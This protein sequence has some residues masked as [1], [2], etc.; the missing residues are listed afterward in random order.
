MLT[1]KTAQKIQEDIYYNMSA[2]KKVKIT[3][4][5]FMLGKKL[6]TSKTVPTH[7]T[8]RTAKKHQ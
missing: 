7:G 5:F 4:R 8:G 1:P 3:S 6:K 2:E